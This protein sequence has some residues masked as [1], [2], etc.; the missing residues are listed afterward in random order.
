[1]PMKVLLVDDH[2]IIRFGLDKLLQPETDYLVVGQACNGLDAVE[3]ACQLCPDF[4]IMA[5]T[6]PRMNGLEAMRAIR[7]QLPGVRFV[8]QTIHEG[9]QMVLKSFVAGARAY[10][11]KQDLVR[12]LIP[13]LRSVLNGRVYLSH[14]IEGITESDLCKDRLGSTVSQ[15]LTLRERQVIQLLAEGKSSQEMGRILGLG[16]N[17]IVTHRQNIMNKLNLRSIAELTKYAIREGLT[18]LDE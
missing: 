8:V 13:A 6:M 12:E 14:G 17:T 4:I 11:L 15:P 1:M 3:K 2:D 9:R 16:K 10:V 5:I 7:R 18:T